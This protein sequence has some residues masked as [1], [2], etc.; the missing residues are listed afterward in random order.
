MYIV[1]IH[2]IFDVR[3]DVAEEVKPSFW[4]R[5]KGLFSPREK[6]FNVYLDV[7]ASGDF[8]DLIQGDVVHV[9]HQ[10]TLICSRIV[11]RD[12]AEFRSKVTGQVPVDHEPFYKIKGEYPIVANAFTKK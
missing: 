3:S 2:H 8:G 4:E 1:I 12:K 11:R 9:N 6:K 7:K 5:I 10:L